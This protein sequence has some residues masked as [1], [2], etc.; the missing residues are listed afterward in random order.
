MVSPPYPS[1]WPA[2]A[3]PFSPRLKQPLP[4]QRGHRSSN[5]QR[6]AHGGRLR[7]ERHYLGERSRLA[8]RRAGLSWRDGEALRRQRIPAQPEPDLRTAIGAA[9]DGDEDVDRSR[10]RADLRARR[11]PRNGSRRA[12]HRGHPYAI[13]RHE[14]HIA[15]SHRLVTI[16]FRYDIAFSGRVSLKVN[17]RAARLGLLARAHP[18]LCRHDGLYLPNHPH[19][20]TSHREGVHDDSGDAAH[21]AVRFMKDTELPE[22]GGAVIIRPLAK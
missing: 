13:A 14:A 3:V 2:L 17:F 20:G 7:I 5:E 19:Q 21:R 16:A 22:E 9:H 6:P 15:Q 18:T 1:S 12:T 4:H 8:P 11:V 10:K